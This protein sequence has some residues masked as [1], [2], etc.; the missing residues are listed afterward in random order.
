MAKIPEYQ[1][2]D[3]NCELTTCIFS[4]SS[5]P[6]YDLLRENQEDLKLKWTWMGYKI[7]VNQTLTIETKIDL[8]NLVGKY[9]IANNGEKIGEIKTIPNS[10]RYAYT[11]CLDKNLNYDIQS[12][13]FTIG[14][15]IDNAEEASNR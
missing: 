9:N 3:M 6:S 14:I 11:I 7:E 15:A 2:L 4:R 10:I 12:L 1:N 13:A 5:F 8:T